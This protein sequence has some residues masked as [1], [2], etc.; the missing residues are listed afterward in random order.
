MSKVKLVVF[1]IAGTTIY[2]DGT[3]GKSFQDAMQFYGY[4]IPILK[5]NELMGYKKTEAI[6]KMLY[7]FEP[8]NDKI[9]N[10]FINEIHNH[11]LKLMVQYYNSTDSLY[12]LPNTLSTFQWLKEQGIKIG[13]DTG[14]PLIITN[15]IMRRIGW[16]KNHIVDCVISSD[17]V[18]AGRP[19]PFMIWEIMKRLEI[20][21]CS[22]V[23][24]VGDTEVDINEGRNAKCLYSIGIT[25]GAFSRSS[26]AVYEPSF[27]I[28][29]LQELI[30][31][32]QNVN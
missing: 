31:I 2:D 7:E 8:N 18:E 23:I 28:D 26:L 25:T 17:E 14:F 15:T 32:V 11:F 5:I 1:D 4:D 12:A 10:A 24:K 13:L 19:D 16:V 27:I 22:S 6:Q 30:A 29:D 21:E 3:I 20:L 9:N